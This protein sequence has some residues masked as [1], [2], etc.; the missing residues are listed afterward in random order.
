MF[1]KIKTWLNPESKPPVWALSIQSMFNALDLQSKIQRD[2]INNLENRQ[3]LSLKQIDNDALA[4][5]NLTA[6]VIELEADKVQLPVTIKLP[7]LFKVGDKV[8][9]KNYAVLLGDDFDGKTGRITSTKFSNSGTG[10]MLYTVRF[11]RKIQGSAI[12]EFYDDEIEF[13]EE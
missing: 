3:S 10:H 7:I 9:V 1:E 13:V 8:Q 6:R 5:A 11:P 12:H 2:R 4:V